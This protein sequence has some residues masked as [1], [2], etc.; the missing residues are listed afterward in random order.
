MTET[1]TTP[2]FDDLHQHGRW[3]RALA[4]SLTADADQALEVEQKTWLAALEKPP[5]HAANPRAWL[6]AVVRNMAHSQWREQKSRNNRERLV[7]EKQWKKMSGDSAA[8]APDSLA[9]RLETVHQ[10]ADA[11]ANLEEP[12]A[13]LLYLR[14]FEELTIQQIGKRLGMPHSTVHAR[15]QRGLEMLRVQL[16]ASMGN[17]WRQ[18][19]LIFTLPFSKSVGGGLISILSMT[20]ST[21][22]IVGTLAASLVAL[23]AWQPWSET[24]EKSLLDDATPIA[25]STVQDAF[26]LEEARAN[27]VERVRLNPDRSAPA[28]LAAPEIHGPSFTIQVLDAVSLNPISN[29]EILYYDT[30]ASEKKWESETKKEYVGL[31]RWME[32]FCVIYTTNEDGILELPLPQGRTH[33][34]ARAEGLFGNAP[35]LELKEDGEVVEVLMRKVR[36]Q[37][38]VVVD[39]SGQ[40]AEGVEV[41]FSANISGM[42]MVKAV[43][44]R[45]GLA[46]LRH[47]EAFHAYA[48]SGETVV[49]LLVPCPSPQS[50]VLLREELGEADLHFVMPATGKVEVVCLYENGRP[51][52]GDL[53]VRLQSVSPTGRLGASLERGYQQVATIDGIALFNQVGVGTQ[54]AMATY[55]T[56]NGR[57]VHGVGIGPSRPGDLAR[58]EL[59]FANLTPTIAVDLTDSKQHPVVDRELSADIYYPTQEGEMQRAYPLID[60]DSD[61]RVEISVDRARQMGANRL[62]ILIHS[63]ESQQSYGQMDISFL[64]VD[65]AQHAHRPEPIPATLGESIIVAGVVVGAGGQP[66]V[67]EKLQLTFEYVGGPKSRRGFIRR[68]LSLFTDE[69]GGFRFTGPQNSELYSYSLAFDRNPEVQFTLGEENLRLEK[70]GEQELWGRVLLDDPAWHSELEVRAVLR[71]PESNQEVE[72]AE[73]F[74]EVGNGRFRLK[75]MPLEQ[76][77]LQIHQRLNGLGVLARLPLA[78]LQLTASD[79]GT[80]IPDWDLRGE[81]FRH[82]LHLKTENP[83]WQAPPTEV[84]SNLGRAYFWKIKGNSVEIFHHEARVEIEVRASPYRP[85]FCYSNGEVTVTFREGISVQF[86]VP[87]GVVIPKD[88]YW[89]LSLR[90]HPQGDRLPFDAVGI[91]Q[92]D[93][94]EVH[95]AKLQVEGEWEVEIIL[96][97]NQSAGPEQPRALFAD[98]STSFTISVE[99]Q[100]EEQLFILPVT[101][102]ALTAAALLAGDE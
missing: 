9:H 64:E 67:N 10:L 83:E 56:R 98:G 17:D 31:E 18:Q 54:L 39:E 99:D 1:P 32:Y 87:E 59:V 55:S 44:N 102:E 47:L 92:G 46:E 20:L 8:K 71:S 94:Q 90:S 88:S 79:D 48:Y 28:R 53:Y 16:A 89:L 26:P 72:F 45:E 19:C 29:V 21:K 42:P 41:G 65:L 80:Q 69:N 11:L 96:I 66:L 15:I 3:V 2:N 62:R 84:L 5:K 51:V 33:I 101:S 91:M 14:F 25:A 70:M 23:V 63:K 100:T 85:V 68:Q 36:H 82:I 93:T 40:P 30:G 61:G 34:S 50:K 49:G 97:T 76:V 27:P 77:E 12:Y 75:G 73:S 13:T 58:L 4:R 24:S 37:R 22:I 38:V 74:I 7:G 6:G 35:S 86:A 95:G 60:A 43:T 52:E 81:I 78:D 57:Y